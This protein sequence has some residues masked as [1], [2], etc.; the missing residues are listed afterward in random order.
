M[1]SATATRR[2]RSLRT[3]RC[4]A[5][6]PSASTSPPVPR[7]SLGHGLPRFREV[8]LDFAGVAAVDQGFCDGLFRVWARAHPETRLLPVRMK[9]RS[10]SWWNAP[11]TTRDRAARAAGATASYRDAGKTSH[12]RP[13]TPGRAVSPRRSLPTGPAA[14]RA[15]VRNRRGVWR[16]VVHRRHGDGPAFQAESLTDPSAL[17]A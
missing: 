17:A 2:S 14:R 5:S 4:F 10:P 1:P 9:R 6:W 11:A 7:H 15:P 16:R 12:R 8:V 13:G 3:R